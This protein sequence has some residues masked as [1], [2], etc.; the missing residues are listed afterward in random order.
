MESVINK[1]GQ[2]ESLNYY[3]QPISE[4]ILEVRTPYLNH[5]NDLI[6]LY[7]VSLENDSTTC[8]ISDDGYTLSEF[9]LMGIDSES[10]QVELN[11]IK[12]KF[13]VNIEGTEISVSSSEDTLIDDFHKMI[14]A[15]IDIDKILTNR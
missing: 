8:F 10:Y 4:G 7:V 12:G 11:L 3:V 13:G 2:L 5:L 6:I 9:D 15:I 1:I 14:H